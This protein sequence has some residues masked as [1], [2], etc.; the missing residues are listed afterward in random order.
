MHV[1]VHTHTHKA[2]REERERKRNR[3]ENTEVPSP[4]LPGRRQDRGV[5]V[6]RGP[7]LEPGFSTR[8]PAL[9][10]SQLCSSPV[11]PSNLNMFL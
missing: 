5:P 8:D 6:P 9:Q 11:Q 3:R 2:E 4:F 7:A 10:Q 1:H